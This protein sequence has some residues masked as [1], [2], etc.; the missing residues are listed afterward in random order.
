[1]SCR[2]CSR[3]SAAKACTAASLLWKGERHFVA[4]AL[5]ANDFLGIRNIR[6]KKNGSD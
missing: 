2:A 5:H 6:K 3:C 4:D 1:M